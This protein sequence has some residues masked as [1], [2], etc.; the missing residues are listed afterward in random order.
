MIRSLLS[1]PQQFHPFRSLALSRKV[2]DLYTAD[3]VCYTIFNNSASVKHRLGRASL[4][5]I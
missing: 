1:Y 3:K 4:K 2:S 5:A